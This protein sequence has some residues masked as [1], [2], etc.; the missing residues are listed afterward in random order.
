MVTRLPSWPRVGPRVVSVGGWAEAQRDQ[1]ASVG[2]FMWP[3]RGELRVG[4]QLVRSESPRGPAHQGRREPVAE[5]TPAPCLTGV[6][7]AAA[8]RPD[9]AAHACSGSCVPRGRAV[10]PLS[11]LGTCSSAPPARRGAPGPGAVATHSEDTR[12]WCAWCRQPQVVC[13]AV[14]RPSPS[15]AGEA[16][17]VT[18]C[19]QRTHR[20]QKRASFGGP[21][22]VCPCGV[23]SLPGTDPRWG[24]QGPG[25]PASERGQRLAGS[26]TQEGR[27]QESSWCVGGGGGVARPERRGRAQTGARG[28][29]GAR[30]VLGAPGGG[31]LG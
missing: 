9:W 13:W 11:L 25:P 26:P 16:V 8:S 24:P 22:A 20:G 5:A 30:E 3:E 31:G 1:V 2:W 15:V 10:C 21:G 14:A 19:G 4:S 18:T 6:E 27:G 28:P 29:R 17:L 7:V 23:A 12:A